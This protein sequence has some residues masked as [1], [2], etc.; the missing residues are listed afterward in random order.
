MEKSIGRHLALAWFPIADSDK[1]KPQQ[2]GSAV[3]F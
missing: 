3:Q 1:I 2:M